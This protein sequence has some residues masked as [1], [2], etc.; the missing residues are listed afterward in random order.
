MEVLTAGG[1]SRPKPPTGLTSGNILDG[2][3]GFGGQG[4]AATGSPLATGGAPASPPPVQ[5]VR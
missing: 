5:S 1:G 4:P 3:S 2:G